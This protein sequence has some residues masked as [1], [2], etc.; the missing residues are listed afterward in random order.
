MTEQAVTSV[1]APGIWR[2]LGRAVR[3][4]WR[5]AWLAVQPGATARSGA[6]RALALLLEQVTTRP[7]YAYVAKHNLAS[8]RVLEKC[9][10]TITSED[11]GLSST[12]GEEV[13]EVILTLHA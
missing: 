10:F 2:R 9:G 5:R 7:L 13:K 6:T 4:W 8:I 12:S 3:A 1:S 11:K